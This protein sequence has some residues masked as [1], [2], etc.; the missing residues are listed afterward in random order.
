MSIS[1][2]KPNFPLLRTGGRHFFVFDKVDDDDDETAE[3]L[4]DSERV[5]LNLDFDS[6]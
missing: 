2:I 5:L 1:H 6:R 3:N 4:S